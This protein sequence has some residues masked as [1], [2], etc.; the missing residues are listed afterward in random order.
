MA[1]P[2]LR[3]PVG[4]DMAGFRQNLDQAKS[5]TSTATS[6]MLKEFAKTQL[7][8]AV[9]SSQF[10]PAVQA[11]AKFLGDQF[12]A[13]KPV[14][15]NVTRDAVRE[16]TAAS[17]KIAD[18]FAKPAITGSFQAFSAVAVPAAQGFASALLPVAAR[19]SVVAAAALLVGDAIGAAR[20]QIADMI[21]VADKASSLTVS[22]QFLQLFE[23]ESRKLKITTDELDQAL[24][25]AYSATKDK[26]PIDVGKWEAA[27]ERITDVE[28]ALRVYNQQLEKATGKQLQGLV[29]FRDADSQDAKVRAVLQAMVQ[30]EQAGQRLQALDIGE[31]MFGSHFVDR[32]RQGK[33]SAESILA[34][35]ESLKATGDGIYPDAI[36]QRAKAV[37]DQLK[38]S[39]DRLSRAMKPAWD[40]LASVILTIKGYW[41]DVVDLMARAIELANRIGGTSLDQ[42]R[43]Q[44]KEVNDRLAGNGSG[45]MGI[46]DRITGMPDFVR[47]NLEKS[48]DDLQAEIAKRTAYLPAQAAVPES[49]GTGAAPVLRDKPAAAASTE[50]N[51]FDGA[52]GSMEKRIAGLEAEAN[53][54][55][56]GTA[57]RERARIAAELETVAK[58]ANAAAGLGANVVTA[59]QR[60]QIDLLADAYGR[61]AERIEQSRSPLATYTREAADLSKQ[62]N[63]AAASNLESMTDSL[64]GVVTGTRSVT[65][66]FRSMANSIISDLA[67]IAIRKTIT[68]PLSAGLGA[69]FGFSDGGMVPAFADG[70]VIR[71]PGGP[72]SDSIVARVS[73]GEYIVNAEATSRHLQLLDA[74]NSGRLPAFADGGYVAPSMPVIRGGADAGVSVTFAPQVDARGADVAAVTRLEQALARQQREFEGRVRQI[75]A[76]RPKKR[77]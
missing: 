21:A 6:F 13:V 31:R 72:R 45:A 63:Y 2:A 50:R 3:I 1:A 44:L 47:Q 39:E 15:Q 41:A 30:L 58:Q 14:I 20:R 52:A 24:T 66:A 22:P 65:D 19:L 32:I 37:D 42:L 57:A 5:L 16:S 25:H 49:R 56:L 71:G 35:M 61:V 12:N 75:V 33:T 73:A 51:R 46:F 74:I 64:S 43:D 55:N 10:K 4:L 28:L 34:T 36:V 54:I 9:N 70:G 18:A 8:L 27:G 48:R 60:A 40:D 17:L 38:A 62:L 7:T 59:E 53:A 67:R 26:S 69:I 76:D 29:I 68:G 11:S 77:W 23:A